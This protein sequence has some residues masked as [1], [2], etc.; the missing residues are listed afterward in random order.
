MTY[1]TPTEFVSSTILII[2]ILITIPTGRMDGVDT[3]IILI[4]TDITTITIHGI[5]IPG[6][7]DRHG[8]LAITATT[9]DGMADGTTTI[10]PITRG[11]HPVGITDRAAITVEI[12]IIVNIMTG[13]VAPEGPMLLL[14]EVL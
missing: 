12:I 4:H 14:Q 10:H 6:F 3:D 2:T 5:T 7:T 11:T 8:D 9:T 13:N 1:R